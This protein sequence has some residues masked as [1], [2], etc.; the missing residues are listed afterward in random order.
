M[1]ADD[2]AAFEQA[3]V[4]VLAA[5]NQPPP[6]E[7]VL[8]LWWAVLS[9][10]PWSGVG[11]AL[12]AHVARCKFPPRPAD[13]LER[14]EAGDGRPNPDE[15]WSLALS[16]A[17]EASTVVWTAEIAAA[18][19]IARPVLDAGDEVGARKT[20]LAA[21]ARL[22]GEARAA[23]R[24]AAWCASLGND[25]ALRADA[26]HRAAEQGKL[27][28][29]QVAALLPP[30][31]AS[32]GAR[33]GALPLAGLLAGGLAALP[34]TEHGGAGRLLT[35]LREAIRRGAA[36]R[37]AQTERRRAERSALERERDAAR[38]E[39]RAELERRRRAGEGD[40]EQASTGFRAL[41]K[42]TLGD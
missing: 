26:L 37:A 42:R 22:T 21:Y 12:T 36:E 5:Y 38:A 17:D 1:T 3:L 18:W 30:A 39:V 29:T 25:P 9:P 33:A 27:A 35:T 24:P 13:L 28:P 7:A 4:A 23:L 16:A 2:A 32:S 15:A 34:G 10:H 19:G 8:R 41:E 20:F 14:I 40:E 11:A 6:S 31:E